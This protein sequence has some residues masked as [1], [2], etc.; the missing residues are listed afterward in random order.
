MREFP[1]CGGENSARPGRDA[2]FPGKII[3]L[4]T[5]ALFLHTSACRPRGGFSPSLSGDLK[6]Y[7]GRIAMALVLIAAVPAVAARAMRQ[8]GHF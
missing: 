1:D 5:P 2:V 3:F 7:L 6:K 8:A 4:H